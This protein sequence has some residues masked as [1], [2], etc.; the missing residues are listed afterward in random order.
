MD[1]DKH[2]DLVNTL[3]DRLGQK[4]ESKKDNFIDT[5]TLLYKCTLLPKKTGQRCL[6]KPK[7]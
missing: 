3:G 1:V 2:I 7:S 5:M 6:R 4:A